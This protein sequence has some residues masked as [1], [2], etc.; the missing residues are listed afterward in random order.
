MFRRNPD[1]VAGVLYR[2]EGTC[3]GCG[4]PAPFIRASDGTAYLEVHHKKRL[5]S[6]GEDTV[7]N[8]MATGSNCHR[9]L[10]YGLSAV[11]DSTHRRR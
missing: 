4:N 3:E 2:A 6:G 9:E 10:Y 8:A 7:E 1:V 5:A 11:L